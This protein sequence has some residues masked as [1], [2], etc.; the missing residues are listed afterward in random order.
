[1]TCVQTQPVFFRRALLLFQQK[2]LV[3]NFSIPA[4]SSQIAIVTT[5]PYLVSSRTDVNGFFFLGL[6]YTK[7]TLLCLYLFSSAFL[8]QGPF[9]FWNLDS[10]AVTKYL[11]LPFLMV[12]NG[13]RGNWMGIWQQA[14]YPHSHSKRGVVILMNKA[15][16]FIISSRHTYV[17]S[18]GIGRCPHRGCFAV[19]PDVW[20]L[21]SKP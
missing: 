18:A 9:S 12:G 20:T 8:L 19:T 15:L 7:V 5:V 17:G 2:D 10:H 1:M 6:T 4:F 14:G 16:A 13:V 11:A 21:R 3:L